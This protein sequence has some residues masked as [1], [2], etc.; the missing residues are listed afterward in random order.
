MEHTDFTL[1]FQDG[2]RITDAE[3]TVATIRVQ[4]LGELIAPTG[5]L[6]ACD[7][8]TAF[9][10]TPF[11]RRIMPGRYVVIASLATDAEQDQRIACVMVRLRDTPAVRW[12]MARLEG[13]DD[14][15]LGEEEFFGY[16]VD[17]GVGCFMDAH[18]AVALDARYDS[19]ESYDEA[20][21]DALEANRADNWD[22]ANI[23]IDEASGANLIMFASGWGDG[24]YA[25]Y[26]GYDAQGNLA[27][28]VT[29]FCVV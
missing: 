14:V 10:P 7:P 29:D 11:A 21:I 9:E 24:V 26:W 17:A 22:Y 23:T 6:V 15:T 1:A 28:L 8:L 3:G 18:A 27:C 4:P 20:L 13:Q 2:A 12:E 19:D 25:S 16:P 5:A